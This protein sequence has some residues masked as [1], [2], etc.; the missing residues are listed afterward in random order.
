MAYLSVEK[1]RCNRR[2]LKVN[3][4]FSLI[5][6]V[7]VIVIA[8][9]ISAFA[10]PGY[11]NYI[12]KS[13]A[14][15]AE[16]N[17]TTIY[18]M[19]KRYKLDNGVYYDCSLTSGSCNTVKINTDLGIFIRDPYFTYTIVKNAT[20]GYIA[21]ATRLNQGPCAT[22]TMQISDSNSQISKNCAVW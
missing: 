16:I 17:L 3:R 7:I 21:T 5:E 12:E 1:Y 13:N 6:L 9:I 15:N 18:N 8:G 19:E 10:I 4:G 20:T 14:K 2:A 22:L 11:F